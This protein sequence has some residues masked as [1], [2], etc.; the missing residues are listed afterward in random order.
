[1]ATYQNIFNRVLIHGEPDP[2]VPLPEGGIWERGKA[3]FSRL[4][5]LFGEAQVGPGYLGTTGLVSLLFGIAAFEII[6]LNM[7]ASVGWDPVEFFR[8]LPWLA[9]EP[10]GPE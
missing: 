6:G 10:P 1:M 9:L 3:S 8:L 4:F 5:G 2:G 7:W